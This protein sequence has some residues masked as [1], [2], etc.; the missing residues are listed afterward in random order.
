MR[1]VLLVFFCRYLLPLEGQQ[2]GVVNALKAFDNFDHRVHLRY[3][4]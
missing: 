1:G 3:I 2:M 4:K